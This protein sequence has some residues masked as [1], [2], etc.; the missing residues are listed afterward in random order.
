VGADGIPSEAWKSV[1]YFCKVVL[2]KMLLC[3][4]AQGSFV[5]GDSGESVWHEH[6]PRSWRVLR[7]AGIPKEKCVTE[8]KNYRWVGLQDSLHKA[9]MGCILDLMKAQLSPTAGIATLGYKPNQSVDEAVAVVKEGVHLA[10]TRLPNLMDS[11]G[12]QIRST[13]NTSA[14]RCDPL[15][16]TRWP[17]LMDSGEFQIRPSFWVD[18]QLV[19]KPM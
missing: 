3:Y 4:Y 16:M 11:D 5:E 6:L 13:C 14:N 2:Y 17:D 10:M 18:M 19:R 1:S 12:F 9:Y 15:E 7:L 8:L